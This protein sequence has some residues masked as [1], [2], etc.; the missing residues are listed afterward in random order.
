[1]A[2]KF[3]QIYKQELKSKGIL[4]SLGSAALKQRKERMDIRNVLFGGSGIVSATGQKI[5]GKGFSALG[6]APKLSSDSPQQNAAINALTISSENQEG[7]LKIV[8]KN[9]MNMNSMARDM[10]ITRQN[11]ASMTKKVTGK[12]SRGADALWMGAEKR[13]ALLADKKTTPTNVNKPTESSSGIGGIFS[14]IGNIISGGAGLIGGVVSGL[15][16]VVGKVGGGILGAIGSVLSGVPGGFILATVALAGVA[17]LLK[18][19]SEN[20]DFT[21]LKND[22]LI[23]LGFDPNNK[24]K[25]LTEQILEKIGF[26][27]EQAKR[28]TGVPEQVL[29]MFEDPVRLMKIHTI[30]AFGTLSDAFSS[31]GS[32]FANAI[33]DFFVRNRESILKGM[34]LAIVIPALIRAGLSG[35]GL[36]LAIAAIAGG[37][38]YNIAS[39]NAYEVTSPE[40][41]KQGIDAGEEMLRINQE[42]KDKSISPER[43]KELTQKRQELFKQ[44]F[45]NPEDQKS[46]GTMANDALIQKRIDALTQDRNSMLDER[47]R[48]YKGISDP[49][50]NYQR[51]LKEADEQYPKNNNTP[52]KLDAGALSRYKFSDLSDE[53]KQAFLTAQ[54]NAEGVNKAGT[55]PN[56]LNNPGAMVWNPEWQKQFGGEAGDTVNGRTFAKFPSMA[57]GQAAQRWLWENGKNYKNATLLEGLKR[58]VD[59]G[60]AGNSIQAFENYGTNLE[61]AIKRAKGIEIASLST[62]M[63]DGVRSLAMN[64]GSSAP[65]IINNNNTTNTSSGGT[66]VASS[67]NKDAA[68]LFVTNAYA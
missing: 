12:S 49:G 56:R 15:L 29:K 50:G 26:S 61:N 34:T 39:K 8:A 42:L 16:G 45:P 6:G 11:I 30:A 10:N 58:W 9:T 33:N 54:G 13:N 24:E 7:L 4:S 18:Q 46:T 37:I 62:Q 65:T 63:N 23:G 66:A 3:S 53:Q 31:V 25:T 48:Q 22:I 20:V 57:Q 38:G 55:I 67:W 36:G 52:T 41:A 5:F 14:G 40:E 21:K 59:P 60:S 47:A 19:V 43:R 51:R 28:I 64:N 2:T 27:P 35:S 17:Y 1:M 32:L 68:E 44:L